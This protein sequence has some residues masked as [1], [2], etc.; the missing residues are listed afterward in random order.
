MSVGTEQRK[1]AAEA[2][3][4]QM[5]AHYRVARHLGS[6]GMG[7]VFLAEDRARPGPVL[8]TLQIRR[9]WSA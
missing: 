8:T 3:S 4:G 6:G 9:K 5:I 1:S 2:L 7:E